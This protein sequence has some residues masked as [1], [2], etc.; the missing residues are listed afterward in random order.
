MLFQLMRAKQL[1]RAKIF[2]IQ[3][4]S[5]GTEEKDALLAGVRIADKRAKRNR[6]AKESRRQNRH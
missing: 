3:L 1:K 5:K 4:L 2:A 6:I